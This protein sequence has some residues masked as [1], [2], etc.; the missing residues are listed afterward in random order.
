MIIQGGVL[1]L[2]QH[3]YLDRSNNMNRY[4]GDY[5]DIKKYVIKCEQRLFIDICDR[6]C[7]NGCTYCYVDS[8]NEKQELLKLSQIQ[9]ICEYVD[10][11]YGNAP[12]IISLCP[13]TEPLKS[14]ESIKLILYLT[15]FF[16]PHNSYIQISTKEK[17]PESFLREIDR[18]AEGRLFIN[19]SLPY[20]INASAVEPG[21]APL[22]E[23]LQNFLDIKK[24]PN[25]NA[26]LYI[27]PFS[28]EAYR[29]AQRFIEIIEKY[30]IDTVCVG[31]CFQK[32]TEVPCRSLYNKQ[33]AKELFS[34]QAER[35]ND[36][37][38]ELRQNTTAKVFGSSVCCIYHHFN[39]NCLLD[40]PQY[41]NMLCED[42]ACFASI[43]N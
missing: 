42:C 21:A 43:V 32:G 38:R 10:A 14:P 16:I 25:L 6:G 15:R 19:I 40:I 29:N 28:T 13:N 36:F 9:R 27:K 22:E 30:E 11:E 1:G 3:S 2:F 4:C 34:E 33:I 39:K 12:K 23:R 7:G 35:L 5:T 18:F 24:Y 31:V 41:D 17:I 8:K 20:I 26:C 37:V